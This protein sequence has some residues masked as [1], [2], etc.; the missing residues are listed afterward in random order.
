MAPGEKHKVHGIGRK[1][2]ML[3]ELSDND[4]IIR[5]YSKKVE[6]MPMYIKEG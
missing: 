2:R 4:I 1:I 6:R 5:F 3:P